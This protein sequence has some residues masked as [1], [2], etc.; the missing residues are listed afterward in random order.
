MAYRYHNRFPSQESQNERKMFKEGWSTRFIQNDSLLLLIQIF[1]FLKTIRIIGWLVWFIYNCI[2]KNREKN[3]RNKLSAWIKRVWD[4]YSKQM[5]IEGEE[6]NP[7]ACSVEATSH[8][9]LI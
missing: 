6:A 5:K 2:R 4:E 3:G 9:S 7:P 8:L 1:S